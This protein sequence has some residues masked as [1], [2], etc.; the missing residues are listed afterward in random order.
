MPK[1][2]HHILSYDT[3]SKHCFV[4]DGSGNITFLKLTDTG[5]EFKATLNGHSDSITSLAWDA[6]RKFLYSG[7]L[8]KIVST[9]AHV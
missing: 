6:N 4:G 8:D 7:S 1:K 3:P 9:D 2:L 5:C